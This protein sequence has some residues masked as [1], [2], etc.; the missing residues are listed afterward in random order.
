MGCSFL[1]SN[2]DVYSSDAQARIAPNPNPIN[3]EILDLVQVGKN[4]VA[5]IRYPDCTNF[6]G[7]KICVY[8]NIN[9]SL[10]SKMSEIDPHFSESLISPIAR[11]RPDEKGMTLAIIFA[12]SL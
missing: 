1:S 2:C 9:F 8:E 7:V 12:R 6:E 3:F 4:V 10:L 5:E 11:F